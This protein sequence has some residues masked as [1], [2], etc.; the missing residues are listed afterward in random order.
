MNEMTEKQAQGQ[1][2]LRGP[3]TAATLTF[4]LR[5]SA[6]GLH[7]L[8]FSLQPS[9]FS[10]RNWIWGALVAAVVLLS[11]C[12]YRFSGSGSLPAGI[13][14]VFISV[15]DNR[16]AETGLGNTLTGDLRYEFIRYKRNA[17]LDEAD[18]V[19]SGTVKSLRVETISRSGQYSSPER[20]VTVSVDLKLTDRSG[21]VVWV[22]EG[23][24]D[25]ES[26]RVDSDD[27]ITNVNKRTAVSALSKRL[28]EN[29]Y[30]R[31]TEDF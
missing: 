5:S 1:S 3:Y 11:A 26:Y 20:R 16:T 14:R 27:Q 22:V 18:A 25:S 24:A 7:P 6:F 30:Y 2:V 15:L 23:L 17:N 9:A 29:I 12:G 28:S 21:R 13:G 8:V 4:S 19:L 31:L 10:L